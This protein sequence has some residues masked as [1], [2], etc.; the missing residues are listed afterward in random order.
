MKGTYKHKNIEARTRNWPFVTITCPPW[1][2]SGL[3]AG[4]L[5]LDLKSLSRL[6]FRVPRESLP[7]CV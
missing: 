7:A 4:A 3:L 6:V 5:N 2:A 1:D